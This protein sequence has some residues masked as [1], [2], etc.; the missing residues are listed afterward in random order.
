MLSAVSVGAVVVLAA[1]SA[2]IVDPFT[3]IKLIKKIIG[4][5]CADAACK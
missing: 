1:V 3:L 2:G 4:V 5:K